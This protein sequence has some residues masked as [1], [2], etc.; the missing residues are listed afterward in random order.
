VISSL[1]EISRAGGFSFRE[2]WVLVGDGRYYR[3]FRDVNVGNSLI[4]QKLCEKWLGATYI[5]IPNL[6]QVT[7]SIS[8]QTAASQSELAK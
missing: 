7:L 1:S 4:V 2:D 8:N 6:L 3:V 5:K